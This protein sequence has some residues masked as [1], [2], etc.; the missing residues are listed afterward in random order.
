MRYFIGV[1][2]SARATKRIYTISGILSTSFGVRNMFNK[3]IPHI[4]FEPPF[5]AGD[6]D[7]SELTAFL[8]DFVKGQ[9]PI[10]VRL[11][12]FSDFDH[13]VVYWQVLE[14]DSLS[15][16]QKR[17]ASGLRKNVLQIDFKP[18]QDIWKPRATIARSD[19]EEMTNRILLYLKRNYPEQETFE[20]MDICLFSR[21]ENSGVRKV[22]RNFPFLPAAKKVA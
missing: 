16:V 12:G 10:F 2:L 15:V 4:T 22:L 7:L 14:N 3:E 13:R 20:V 21:D 6:E 19:S 5:E 18:L 8:S 17:L 11:K 1:T 9:P